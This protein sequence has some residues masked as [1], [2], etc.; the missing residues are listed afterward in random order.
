MKQQDLFGFEPIELSESE[1]KYSHK[2][3]TPIYEPRKSAIPNLYACY[4]PQRYL[5]LLRRI[6]QSNVT[7]AEKKFLALAATRFVEFNYES[8]ADYY[9]S[10]SMEMQSL[11][12]KLALVIID[13]DK[14]IENGFV[15]LNDNMKRL[16]EQELEEAKHG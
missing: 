16:Y 9:A 3:N 11:M 7:D 15:Q 14:A 8:I 5:R 2:I 4:D 6:E 1:K 12:E 10:S 13:F